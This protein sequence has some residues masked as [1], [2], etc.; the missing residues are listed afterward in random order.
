MYIKHPTAVFT[1]KMSLGYMDK[2]SIPTPAV[3]LQSDVCLRWVLRVSAAWQAQRNM[4]KNLFKYLIKCFGL[5][6]GVKC[7]SKNMQ[8]CKLSLSWLIASTL[9]FKVCSSS[10]SSPCQSTQQMA[11][12]HADSIHGIPVLSITFYSL[13]FSSSCTMLLIPPW[14]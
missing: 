4:K 1:K 14:F 11:L 8:E 9:L 5:L 10:T 6:G 13:I 7:Y 3:F 12:T 2:H